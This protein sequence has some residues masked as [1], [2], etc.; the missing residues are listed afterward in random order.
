MNLQFSNDSPVNI[1]IER[2]PASSMDN[3][4]RAVLQEAHE[5]AVRHE[6]DARPRNDDDFTLPASHGSR[7]AD[8]RRLGCRLMEALMNR[9]RGAL[10]NLSADE[11]IGLLRSH[12]PHDRRF[13][14]LVR[15]SLTNDGADRFRHADD[16]YHAL[17]SALSF[18]GSS[19]TRKVS[20]PYPTVP[21]VR[22]VRSGQVSTRR[23]GVVRMAALV[24][25][26]GTLLFGPA[27]DSE[28]LPH[29]A[30]LA[31]RS[32]IIDHA[33][34]AVELKLRVSPVG[35]VVR[36][37]DRESRSLACADETVPAEGVVSCGLHPDRVYDLVVFAPRYAV[38]HFSGTWSNL[39]ASIR[40]APRCSQ[41]W[42]WFACTAAVM[43]LGEPA[44]RWWCRAGS[45]SST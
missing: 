40:L 31:V 11:A 10:S 9:E 4:L 32:P 29:G 7:A 14:E 43:V 23:R 12:R 17:R 44:R 5:M 27:R 24:L 41:L 22:P 8:I 28:V 39:P 25:A 6:A 2:G 13:D 26:G 30:G 18:V 42:W 36:L 19:A 34:P 3:C 20:P 16:L 15:R 33:R 45:G 21:L 38:A 37:I 1:S 35:A